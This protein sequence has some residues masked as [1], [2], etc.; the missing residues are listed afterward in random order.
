MNN[1]ADIFKQNKYVYLG[2]KF[3]VDPKYCDF[4]T[5]QLFKEIQNKTTEKDDQCPLSE[6][7]YG[8]EYLDKLLEDI[9]PQIEEASGLKLYPTYSYARIYSPNDELK[10]HRDR[11]SC[12][13]SVTINLGYKGNIWPIYMSHNED[14]SDATK[15]MLDV[16]EG[17]LYKGEEVYHWREPYKEGEW[18]SQVFL[19][20]VDVN[21]PYAEYKYDKR[22]KLA[23]HKSA[24]PT[25][26]VNYE[27]V[28]KVNHLPDEMCTLAIKNGSRP[29]YIKEKGQIGEG[30]IDNDV[31]SVDRLPIPP[32]LGLGATL[33]SWGM[34]ANNDFWKFDLKLANQSELLIYEPGGKYEQHIDTAYFVDESLFVRKL[35]VLGFLN[36]DYE[37]GKFYIVKGHERFYPPQSKGTVLAFPSFLLHGV[38]PVTKGTRYSVVTWLIGPRFI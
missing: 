34:G 26:Q 16:G 21:G 7:I 28:Y 11:P 31:R 14:K 6:A 2:D 29:D 17:A 25:E 27:C 20:Y 15:I 38:E 4:L 22:P 1:H 33:A 9:Q 18:L 32:D 12:E 24:E 19:H 8:Q 5:Q 35:T 37:G 3:K 36:D 13:I 23:H 10:I 30:F